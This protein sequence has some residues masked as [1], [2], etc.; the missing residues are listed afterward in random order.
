MTAVAFE[1]VFSE[2]AEIAVSMPPDYAYPRNGMGPARY[3]H[4]GFTGPLDAA[5]GCTPDP[6]SPGC[7]VAHWLYLHHDVPLATLASLEGKSGPHVLIRLLAEDV[8]PPDFLD[9]PSSAQMLKFLQTVQAHQDRGEP[10]A[11]ALEAAYTLVTSPPWSYLLGPAWH[12][13]GPL[14]LPV[15]A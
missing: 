2:F 7:I 14:S 12:A 9:D 3:V 6:L 8:L 11:Q 1:Q 5:S 15:D 4:G 10:W 13:E